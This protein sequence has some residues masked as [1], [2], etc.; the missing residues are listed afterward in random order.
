MWALFG[1][2]PEGLDGIAVA[3]TDPALHRILSYQGPNGCS[4]PVRQLRYAFIA[5]EQTRSD[6]VDEPQRAAV[7]HIPRADALKVA[8]ESGLD[9]VVGRRN[10]T[11][12]NVRGDDASSLLSA[13]E[14]TG[15][16]PPRLRGREESSQR[17]SLA[18]AKGTQG[19]IGQ[20]AVQDAPRVEDIAV[21][22]QIDAR[23]RRLG[24]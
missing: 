3:D 21:P 6:E 20:V 9:Q 18:D 5:R 24:H 4:D 17:V 7:R 22:Y 16:D 13:F 12:G 19:K 1:F 8:A 11:A 14:R 10:G 23:D 15:E 2:D